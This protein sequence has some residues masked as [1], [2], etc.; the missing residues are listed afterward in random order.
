MNEKICILVK[1]N[2]REGTFN[3]KISNSPQLFSSI[4]VNKLKKEHISR[5]QEENRKQIPSSL[6]IPLN[7]RVPEP[8]PEDMQK[9]EQSQTFKM[10]E[11]GEL[12]SFEDKTARPEGSEYAQMRSKFCKVANVPLEMDLL[13]RQPF[14]G[15]NCNLP[16]HP[17]WM[18]THEDQTKFKNSMSLVHRVSNNGR[19][20]NHNSALSHL[21]APVGSEISSCNPLGS[22][23]RSHAYAENENSQQKHF[24]H[25]NFN[26]NP[27]RSPKQLHAHVRGE[28]FN[29]FRS[30]V[31]GHLQEKKQLCRYYAQGRCYYGYNCKYL[32]KG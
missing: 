30:I 16:G 32:H 24:Y 17:S 28:N 2:E 12:R 22:S 31:Q 27:L 20:A 15:M 21:K 5:K 23:T 29:A 9:T 11:C 18:N 3:S 14:T 8:Q 25:G 4:L 26:V 7:K 13:P 1:M 19:H 10:K 6:S